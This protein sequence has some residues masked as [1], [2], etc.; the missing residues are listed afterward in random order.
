MRKRV[1]VGTSRSVDGIEEKRHC[2]ETKDILAFVFK[3]QPTL[4]ISIRSELY[5]AHV[6][7]I[8]VSSVAEAKENPGTI[9]TACPS[10]I[11]SNG[12]I[13]Q[14]LL[15]AYRIAYLRLT[16]LRVAAILRRQICSFK[17]II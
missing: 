6:V 9:D 17:A 1:G 14:Q 4:K 16:T 15:N 7:A 12:I 5:A 8:R 10:C 2:L 3:G 11:G 13:T